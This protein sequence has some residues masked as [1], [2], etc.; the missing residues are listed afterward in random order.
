MTKAYNWLLFNAKLNLDQ[1][2]SPETVVDKMTFPHQDS[3]TLISGVCEYF[4]QQKKPHCKCDE[5]KELEKGDYPG[6]SRWA[7]CHH[8]HPFKL[9]GWD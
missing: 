1:C 7:H 9:G 5:A 4:T 8:K 6:L 2:S 3:H